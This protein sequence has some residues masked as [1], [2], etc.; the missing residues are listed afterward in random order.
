MI[1][2]EFT[3]DLELHRYMLFMSMSDR[4]IFYNS[5]NTTNI[6]YGDFFVPNSDHLL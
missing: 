3:I 1:G 6:T 4:S 5:N 2:L